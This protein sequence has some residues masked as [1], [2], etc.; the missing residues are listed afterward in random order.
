ML[1]IYQLYMLRKAKASI[2]IAMVTWHY[3]HEQQR[4]SVGIVGG[5]MRSVKDSDIFL[6]TL[7]LQRSPSTKLTHLWIIPYQISSRLPHISG[8]FSLCFHNQRQLWYLRVKSWTS[9]SSLT[10]LSLKAC[11]AREGPRPSGGS[12]NCSLPQQFFGWQCW[13]GGAIPCSLTQPPRPGGAAAAAPPTANKP[14][15]SRVLTL[16]LSCPR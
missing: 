8:F 2:I 1:N 14:P 4:R 5:G 9:F 16:G 11:S 3:S 12:W 7:S 6:L 10:A 13:M 15:C